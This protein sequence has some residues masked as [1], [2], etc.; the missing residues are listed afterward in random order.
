ML[1]FWGF[2]FYKYVNFRVKS[3]T[4]TVLSSFTFNMLLFADEDPDDI[5]TYE[6]SAELREYG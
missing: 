6:F 3:F 2:P 5:S 1:G 4:T